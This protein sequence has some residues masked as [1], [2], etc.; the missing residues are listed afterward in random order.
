M[1]FLVYTTAIFWLPL[2][3]KSQ[4]NRNSFQSSVP[5][6]KAKY[7]C[8]LAEPSG[9]LRLTF[10]PGHLESFC[11]APWILQVLSTGLPSLFLRAQLCQGG[12]FFLSY[13][14][15]WAVVWPWESNLQP[16]ILQAL[17]LAPLETSNKL[18]SCAESLV[19]SSFHYGHWNF[20]VDCEQSLFFFR[21]SEGSACVHDNRAETFACLDG[22]R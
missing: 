14:R 19:P 7:G 20:D 1:I 4:V 2:D 18:H 15:P 9:P 12:T 21:V 3:A 22:L 10:A 11:Q 8:A 5:F 13:S 17:L 16:S 6:C